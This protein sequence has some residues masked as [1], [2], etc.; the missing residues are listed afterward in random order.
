MSDPTKPSSETP[1]DEADVRPND[2]A[3]DTPSPKRKRGP[4]F[5]ILAF[6]VLMGGIAWT[7]HFIHEAIA[8]EKTDDA[9]I[10]GHV[11][12]ISPGIA[13]PVSEILVDDNEEVK[14]G[15]VLARIDPLE[16]DIAIEKSKADEEQA[17]ARVLQAEAGL[18]RAKSDE[19]Q[20][21]AAIAAAAAQVNQAEAQLSLA[22]INFN[23][24]QSLSH[25]DTR[26]VSQSELDTTRSAA[27][28]AEAALASAKANV[29]AAEA[30]KEI[31]L[32]AIEAAK[33][34]IVSA[35]AGIGTAAA[36]TK[37]ALRQRAYVDITAPANGLIGNKNIELGNRVQIA[38][39][40]FALV[41]EDY[42]IVAN[43]KETQL[44]NMKAGQAVDI[45]ID[46]LGGK[47]VSGKLDSISPSTGAQFAL[48]PADN[49]T[50][51]FT[52][53][54]QRVPVKILFDESALKEIGPLLRPG[55]STVIRVKVK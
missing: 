36:A 50:G 44:A 9:Y 35:K 42:W 6:L 26:A 40:V 17:K 1:S 32:A 7:A 53:V 48:L 4:V 51:N 45:E 25:G 21:E 43:F 24:N 23:R 52:K 30:R 2:S 34:D 28:S 55:L 12:R 10:I 15:Q 47:R 20:T 38:Q 8:F 11:H 41:E 31:S 49:A 18:A 37:E 16:Y 54:V 22:N 39:P 29:T 33:A 14:A 3:T 13:G 19:L 46:A 5:K 27:A